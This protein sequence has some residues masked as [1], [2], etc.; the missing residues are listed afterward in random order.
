MIPMPWKRTREG[1]PPPTIKNKI[2]TRL[3]FNFSSRST[4]DDDALVRRKC[5]PVTVNLCFYSVKR[6]LWVLFF[7]FPDW[8]CFTKNLHHQLSKLSFTIINYTCSVVVDKL[9]TEKSLLTIKNLSG[10]NLWVIL[11]VKI[12]FHFI[13]E[14]I[15]FFLFLK[16]YTTITG[17][18]E[19]IFAT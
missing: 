4:P 3:I 2:S 16:R 10:I 19:Y 9:A 5:V 6:T 18:F 8:K 17:K 11:L 12:N 15:L 1:S 13:D 7:S 14:I